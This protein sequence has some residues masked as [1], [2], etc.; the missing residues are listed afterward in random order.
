MKKANGP[1]HTWENRD[2]TTAHNGIDIS[3]SE[4]TPV[5]SHAGVMR[6]LSRNVWDWIVLGADERGDRHFQCWGALHCMGYWMP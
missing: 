4:C 3:A 1:I 2:A 6:I 5:G